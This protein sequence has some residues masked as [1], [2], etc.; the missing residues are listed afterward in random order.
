M[1]E[2]DDSWLGSLERAIEVT[3]G[4][5]ALAVVHSIPSISVQTDRAQVLLDA[6]RDLQRRVAELEQ[7]R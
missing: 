5:I 4:Q 3:E 6:I 1:S 7:R 2:R